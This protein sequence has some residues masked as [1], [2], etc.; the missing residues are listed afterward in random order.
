MKF[1]SYI[2]LSKVSQVLSNQVCMTYFHQIVLMSFLVVKGNAY[3]FT[4]YYYIPYCDI[5]FLTSS[6]QPI[7][8]FI[9]HFVWMFHV[10][11]PT[12]FVEIGVL[13]LF[14]ME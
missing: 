9:S 1:S 11:T 10:W 4:M 6:L 14:L 8:G 12:K 13:P 2:H 5:T 3:Q 7:Y